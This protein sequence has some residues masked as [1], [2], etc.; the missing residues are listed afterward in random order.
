MNKYKTVS[1]QKY[2]KLKK[3]VWS[4]IVQVAII[5]WYAMRQRVRLDLHCA[6]S[7]T[8]KW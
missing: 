2:F 7:E 4:I 5:D 8:D 3:H 1:F 6:F